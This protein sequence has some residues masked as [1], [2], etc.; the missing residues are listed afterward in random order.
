MD[1][2]WP[3]L[4]FLAGL[5]GCGMLI[6]ICGIHS[7]EVERADAAPGAAFAA[8]RS[9]FATLAAAFEPPPAADEALVRAVELRLRRQTDAAARFIERPSIERFQDLD[10]ET[11][12]RRG[13]TLVDRVQRFVAAER[14]AAVEFVAN[15]SFDRFH[16]RLAVAC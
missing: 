6:L 13:P 9:F 10:D 2:A 11:G 16:G 4:L 7:R 5:L 12:P 1:T 14:S 8:P 3:M 15:P